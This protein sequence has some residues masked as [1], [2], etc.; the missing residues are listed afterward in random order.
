MR[1]RITPLRKKRADGKK[2]IERKG[3]NK[4]GKKGK[5]GKGNRKRRQI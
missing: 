3:R 5:I 1:M 4:R 2:L